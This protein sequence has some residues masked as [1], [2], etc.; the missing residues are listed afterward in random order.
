MKPIPHATTVSIGEQEIV[1]KTIDSFFLETKEF[2]GKRYE[3]Q[4]SLFRIESGGIA[5]RQSQ[6]TNDRIT[7]FCYKDSVLASV[8]ET[9]TEFNNIR[10][11]F[12]LGI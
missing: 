2:I 3:V 11:T 12:F 5:Y 8:L 1:Q 10:F 9:R 6:I 7:Y 4:E